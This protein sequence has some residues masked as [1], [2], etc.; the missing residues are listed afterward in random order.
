MNYCR[1]R[2]DVI[3]RMA[4]TSG[5]L[6]PPEYQQVEYLES[7]G[8]ECIDTGINATT[9]LVTSIDFAVTAQTSYA[10]LAFIFGAY[11]PSTGTIPKTAYSAALASSTSIRVPNSNLFNNVTVPAMAAG[12]KHNLSY[13]FG[14]IKFDG[15]QKATYSGTA[16]TPAHIYLFRRNYNNTVDLGI[17]IRIYSVTIEDTSNRYGEFIPCYRK[18]DNKPGM[19]DIV[20]QTFYTNA[21]TGEFTVGNNV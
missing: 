11:I 21:G 14:S 9:T 16:S 17:A 6:L 8:N 12:V 4:V 2:N 1:F 10:N 20:T 19:Y 3:K 18:A 15:T 13:K 7:S 5:G